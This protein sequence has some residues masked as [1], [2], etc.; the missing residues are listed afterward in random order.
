MS[1]RPLIRG[2]EFSASG[3]SISLNSRR[4]ERLNNK[5]AAALLIAPGLLTLGYAGISFLVARRVAYA[6]P[7]AITKTPAD[8]GLSYR[9]VSFPSRE[10]HLLL[11]GWFIPGVLPDGQLT[12]ERTIIMVH[13]LHSNRAALE[14]GLLDLSGALARLGFAILAFDMRGQGQSAP[15]P[16]SMGYYEQFDV[17][18][19][20]D[21]L[22][23]YAA[24]ARRQFTR[25]MPLPGPTGEQNEL[26]LHGRG[27]FASI[28]PW[29]F[30][31]AI[32]T[33]LV[34]APLAAGNVIGS[35][36][37]TSNPRSGRG[38]CF[39]RICATD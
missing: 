24:E 17:L 35:G 25:P 5:L 9:D 19:A 33:G 22:R 21:F 8:I 10:N 4:K 15:A 31:L 3:E 12:T 27:V 1:F 32:F 37:R 7:K 29:N 39:R 13:G 23:F 34:S 36:A 30:P 20:V 26:R 38:L 11:R 6:Q 2:K 14:A 28:S 16:L 18:G